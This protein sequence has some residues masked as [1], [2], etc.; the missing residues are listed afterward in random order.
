M[1]TC[2]S[3]VVAK[4]NRPAPAGPAR[5]GRART[6]NGHSYA[7]INENVS[8]SPSQSRHYPSCYLD[9]HRTERLCRYKISTLKMRPLILVARFSSAIARTPS[10]LPT[11]RQAE[12]K[13]TKSALSSSCGSDAS[14]PPFGRCPTL[15]RINE[16]GSVTAFGHPVRRREIG[17]AMLRS[18]RP[19]LGSHMT[20]LRAHQ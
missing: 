17:G 7:A 4:L 6:G 14:P 5:G 18:V 11:I 3:D 20:P 2:L 9:N 16:D 15:T 12:S 13:R 19:S 1:L 10:L 8:W